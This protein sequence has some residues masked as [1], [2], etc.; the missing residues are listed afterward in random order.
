ME[1]WWQNKEREVRRKH[2]EP[3]PGTDIFVDKIVE[4]QDEK[5]TQKCQFLC[6]Y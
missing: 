1:Q 6:I 2:L 3:F 4:N 5:P